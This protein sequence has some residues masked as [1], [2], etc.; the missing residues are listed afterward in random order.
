MTFKETVKAIEKSEKNVDR[1]LKAARLERYPSN[2]QRLET[3]LS[4]ILTAIAIL[5]G[6]AIILIPLMMIAR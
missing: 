6:T 5:A 2:T 4:A 3:I 1:V